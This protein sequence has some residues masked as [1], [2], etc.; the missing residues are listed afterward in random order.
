VRATWKRWTRTDAREPRRA[1]CALPF[2]G[3]SQTRP[4]L[5]GRKCPPFQA[6]N[7][8][9]PNSASLGHAQPTV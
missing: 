7:F 6:S 4:V 9:Q 2:I 3:L 1:F 5:W 8:V